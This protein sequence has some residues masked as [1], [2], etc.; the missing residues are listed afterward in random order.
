VEHV[1]YNKIKVCQNKQQLT[2]TR[3]SQINVVLKGD[4]VNQGW[5]IS[6]TWRLNEPILE[7]PWARNVC[8]S[9]AVKYTHTHVCANAH[10]CTE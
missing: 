10:A 9:K 5:A 8:G 2:V 4:P 7:R 3:T 1:A 6:Y